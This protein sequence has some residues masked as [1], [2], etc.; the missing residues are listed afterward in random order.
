MK[1]I[2]GINPHKS[3]TALIQWFHKNDQKRHFVVVINEN[4]MNDKAVFDFV[5]KENKAIGELWGHNW[6]GI[7]TEH[8][9]EWIKGILIVTVTFIYQRVVV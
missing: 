6:K 4:S 7:N 9:A 5:N 1:T 2:S 3:I 8:D